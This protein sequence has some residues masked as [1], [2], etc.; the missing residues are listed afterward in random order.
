MDELVEKQAKRCCEQRTTLLGRWRQVRWRL[1]HLLLIPRS[2]FKESRLE[3]FLHARRCQC[4]EAL[5]VGEKLEKERDADVGSSE[6]REEQLGIACRERRSFIS[7][8]SG[9]ILRASSIPAARADLHAERA[10]LER[11][12]RDGGDGNA[13]RRH[14]CWADSD[15]TEQMTSARSLIFER[16]FGKLHESSEA[17]YFRL[18][19]GYFG[20]C[21]AVR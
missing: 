20:R 12:E 17:G 6:I 21:C 4:I 3:H 8:G 19:C 2:W 9:T 16:K 15:G 18:T 5:L 10:R 14:G 7:V 11:R 13:A 1:T